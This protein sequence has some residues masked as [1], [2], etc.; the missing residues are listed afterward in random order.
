[1][2]RNERRIWVAALTCLA[3]TAG[4]VTAVTPAGGGTKVPAP[5][6]RIA[7]SNG[8][9]AIDSQTLPAGRVLVH[10]TTSGRLQHALMLARLNGGV[11]PQ[12]FQR[13]LNTQDGQAALALASFRGGVDA[14]P[15]G[16]WDMVTDLRPGTYVVVDHAEN[17][18]TP[19]FDHGGFAT[20]RVTNERVR[21]A[22]VPAAR[23]SITMVDFAFKIRLQPSFHGH[24]WIQVANRGYANHRIILL[25]LNPGVSFAMAYAAIRA[26]NDKNK[27]ERPPGQPIEMLGA[28]SS[29]FVGY[30][31]MN[32]PRGRYIA[33]CFEADS[34][35]HF[36]S[37][38]ELGMIGRFTIR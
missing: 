37:H 22:P 29:G 19:N 27:H 10:V 3:A 31:K 13:A 32:L 38:V 18:G 1:V 11:N 36:V 35:T 2:K 26:H 14:L 30:L 16:S 17:G 34:K 9:L 28:V 4:A 21:Q 15:P 8:P 7:M 33:A 12:Q 24:G 6:L 23:G 5:T 20:I 25:R